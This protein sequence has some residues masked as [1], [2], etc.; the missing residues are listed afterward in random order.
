MEGDY[1]FPTNRLRSLQDDSKTPLVFVACG[2]F[3]PVTFLHLRMFEMA[4]DHARVHTEFEVVGGYLSLVNDAYKKPGLAA[5]IHRYK[6]CEIACEETSDWLMV[7]P[8]EA[9]QIEY[10]PT[11]RVLDHFDHQLNGLANGVVSVQ[12]G[13]RKPI[14]IILLAGSDLIQT[15]S[16]PGLWA[17][18]DLHH[19]LSRYGCYIIER[20]ESEIDQSL[21]SPSS[22]HSRSPLSLYKHQIYMVPQLVRNDVSSTKVR[23]FVRKGMSIEYLIPSGVIKYI[24]LHSL[25]QDEM[26]HLSMSSINTPM[27]EGSSSPFFK[28][29]LDPPSN[30]P[31][32]NP[33]N[34][35]I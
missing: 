14:R 29:T 2:S 21:F 33:S 12:T 18:E 19:I 3:S 24:K 28:H 30:L 9:R 5:S 22:V 16:E 8:W 31:L 27:I 26:S 23:L 35:S 6:M 4:R 7:D 13:Q 17:E 1:N 11:A 25:Y 32:Q 15:M 10:S 20:A 34:L